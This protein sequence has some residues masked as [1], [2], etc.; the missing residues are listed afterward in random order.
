[1]KKKK[2]TLNKQ[3]IV[4]LS[5]EQAS[6]IQGGKLELAGSVNSSNNDFTCCWCTGGGGGTKDSWNTCRQSE[7]FRC[8]GLE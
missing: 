7:C 3:K 8:D 6:Q 5:N 4:N 2:L 1:M